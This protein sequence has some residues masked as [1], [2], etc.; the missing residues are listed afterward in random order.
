MRDIK[1][2]FVNGAK[3]DKKIIN[4]IDNAKRMEEKQENS[5]VAKDGRK[6][7]RVK[8][9]ISR[10]G[11]KERTCDII[12]SKND[13]IDKTPSPFA[14]TDDTRRISQSGTPKS[15]LASSSTRQDSEEVLN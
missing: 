3:I 4:S 5:S 6:R 8:I 1:Q 7:K 14:K 11:S 13:L 9:R 2:Y 12:E 10:A 15:H